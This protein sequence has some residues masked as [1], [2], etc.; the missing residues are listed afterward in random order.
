MNFLKGIL[1]KLIILSAFLVTSLLQ[2]QSGSEL[3]GQIVID[4]STLPSNDV[5]VTN[6]RT[7]ITAKTGLSGTFRIQAQVQDTL[8]IYAPFLESRRFIVS[9]R[10]LELRP[11]MIHMNQEV[12]QLQ[13]VISVAPLTGDLPYDVA[14]ASKNRDV[15]ELYK[16]LG[17]DIRQLDRIPKE[18]I[19]NVFPRIAGIPIPTS[20]DIETLY[21]HL[22]GYYRRMRNLDAFERLETRIHFVKEYFGPDYFEKTL[23]LPYE[24]TH[25]FLL[26]LYDHTNNLYEISY[27]SR[28]MLTMEQLMRDGAPVF[29]ERLRVRDSQ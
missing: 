10:A 7:Q 1:L 2:A 17:L 26:Y 16:A 18:Q 29:K 24:E 3:V 15:E 6:K 19:A 27:H 21:K 8:L 13:D 4:F 11:V 28:D 23:G 9:Q 5:F 22:T 12:V 14:Q 25:G 20:L